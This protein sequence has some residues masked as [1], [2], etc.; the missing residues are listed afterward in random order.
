MIDQN[1]QDKV[2]VQISAKVNLG[3]Y[4]NIDICFGTS[5]TINEGEESA[6]L[7]RNLYED[8]LEEVISQAQEVK[9]RRRDLFY[10]LQNDKDKTEENSARTET[11][12]RRF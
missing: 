6:I 5:R 9:A 4:E 12:K 11:R 1:V 7:R 3:D 2:W 10:K 8:I